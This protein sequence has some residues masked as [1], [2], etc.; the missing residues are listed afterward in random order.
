VVEEG[1]IIPFD[2]SVAVPE[3]NQ[4]DFVKDV[5]FRHGVISQFNSTTKTLTLN[6]FQDLEQNKP[7]AVDFSSKIDLLKPPVFDFTKVLKSFKKTSKITYLKDDEDTLLKL[8]RSVYKRGLG[9]AVVEL[10][11]DN[12]SGEGVVYES[13]FAPTLQSWTFPSP[14]DGDDS[15]SNFYLPTAKFNI[16]DN[17]KELEGRI[18]VKAG[19]ISVTEFNKGGYTEINLDG[20]AYSNVGYAFFAKQS[21][22]ITDKN[23]NLNTDTLSFQNVQSGTTNYIGNTLL[24]RNYGLYFSLLKQ[25]VH[26]TI[27][28]NLKPLDMQQLDFFKPIWLID[29]YYYLDNVSQYKGDGTTTSVELVKM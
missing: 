12:L 27:N 20:S 24:E 25:P 7:F 4:A 28:L 29:S 8:F 15:L 17:E 22:D 19:K 3:I 9:D 11:N 13:V 14:V 1:A 6:K 26:L 23:L 5:M 10:D 2:I 18:Y 16:P 21:L